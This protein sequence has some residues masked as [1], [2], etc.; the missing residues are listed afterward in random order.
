VSEWQETEIGRIPSDWDTTNLDSISVKVTD[1]AHLSPKF[2]NDGRLMCSIKDMRYN[3][4][5]FSDCKRISEDDFSFLKRQGCSPKKGDILISKDGEK[6]L[7]LIFVYSQNQEIVLLSSIAIVRLNEKNNPHFHRY[8]LLSPVGQSIM[9]KWFRSGSAIP[10]VVLKDFRNVPVPKVPFHEQINIANILLCLDAKIDNLQKQNQTLEK[11]AQTLFKQWF[12]DFNFPDENGN[13]YK[14]NGGEMVESELGEI[15]KGWRVGI[16]GEIANIVDCLHSKKP[17]KIVDNTG[18][19]LLQ[20][21]NIADRGIL[22]LSEKYYISDNDYSK[23]ISRIEISEGDCVITNVGR[24][25]AVAQIPKGVKAALGR[26]MTGIRLKQKFNHLSAFLKV[27]LLSKSMYFE[28][29]RLKDSG[30][31]LDALNVKNIPKLR[32]KNPGEKNLCNFQLVIEANMKKVENNVFEIQTLTKTRD[33]LLPKLM[34]GQI[35]VRD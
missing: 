12:V 18:N 33:T 22:D 19:I 26:N 23:W 5:D 24:Y 10:R 16:L 7:N 34:S 15:P 11:I 31:I 6:C 3:G 8:Y 29:E 21:N 17:E 25:G 4:F 30:T 28:I 14:D 9:K 35:K 20:L 32:F 1:G 27:L 13:R 2:F